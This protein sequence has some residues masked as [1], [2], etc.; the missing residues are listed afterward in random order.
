MFEELLKQL[1]LTVTSLA[2]LLRRLNASALT[3]SVDLVVVVP[4]TATSV[5]VPHGLGRAANG[6]WA[7]GQSNATRYV[8]VDLVVADETVT[9]RLSAAPA[10]AF[11][12]KLRVY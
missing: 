3:S 6:A 9:V 1:G 4:T 10:A 8:T 11:T 12:V 2:S 5:T 7:V